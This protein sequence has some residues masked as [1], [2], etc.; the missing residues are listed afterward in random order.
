MKECKSCAKL[1]IGTFNIDFIICKQQHKHLI[2]NAQ[3][4]GGTIVSSDHKLVKTTIDISKHSQ[5]KAKEKT[6]CATKARLNIAQLGQNKNVTHNYT[7]L[8]SQVDEEQKVNTQW[9]LIKQCIETAAKNSIEEV[10]KHK[11]YPRWDNEVKHLSDKQKQV[12][13]EILNSKEPQKIKDLKKERNFMLHKIKEKTK[14]LKNEHLDELAS[15]ID[16]TSSDGGIFQA[17]KALNRK[18]FENPKVHDNDGK[19]VSNPRQIQLIIAN[20][21]KSKFRDDNIHDIEPY[22]G[23]LRKLK[24][25]ITEREV[26]ASI[27]NLNNG[28]APGSDNR[29]G[30]FLKFAPHLIDNKIAKILNQTFKR[31]E[32]LNINEGLL[33]ALPKPGKPKGPPQNLRPITLLNSIRKVLSTIVLNRIRPKIETY[34]SHS[35][36]G[37]RPNMSTSAVVWAHR[38]LSAKILNTPNL[39]LNITGIDMS[40]AFDTIDRTLL[41]KTLREIINEDELRIVQFLLS[42][43]TLDVKINGTSTT[44]LFTTNVGTPQGDS[45]SPVLFIVYLENALRNARSKE[46]PK[47][48]LPNEIIYADHIDFVGTDPPNINDIETSLKNFR[49]KVNVDKTE[50]TELRKDKEDWKLTKKVGSLLG[51]KEDIDHRKH[52]SNVVLNKLSNIW[53]RPDKVKQKT[54]N[55]LYNSLVKSILLYN[56]GTWSLTTTDEKRLDSFHRRQLRRILGIHY[57][58]KITN[59]SLYKK[60]SETPLSLQILELRWRLFGHILRRDNSIPANLAMLYYFNENSNRGRGRPTTTLPITL[61]NDLKRLQN[62]DVPLTPKEGLHK[63]QKIASQRQEWIAFTAEIKRTAEE[64]PITF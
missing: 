44:Q 46:T 50:H 22:F 10:P 23:Q 9:K 58:T 51:S 19:Q 59:Q 5:W 17:V 28:R 43:T 26:R 63:M 18:R 21:F 20:H 37:F 24:S 39:Q 47:Q 27:N 42:K 36:S 41:L 32:D 57:P 11:A 1:N 7:E 54:R 53:N 8:L 2:N 33:I 3:S 6:Q 25:P 60:C 16:K 29:S 12:R 48:V 31:H 34:I 15:N 64:Q 55:K 49:L 13:L 14:Q 40:A 56:C 38:W 62:K 35:Q 30:E 45:L 61:N 4:Y 52:L